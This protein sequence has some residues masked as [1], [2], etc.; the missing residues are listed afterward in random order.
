MSRQAVRIVRS[1]SAALK[2]LERA[3]SDRNS[4][5]KVGV[6]GD[7][8]ARPEKG[9]TNAEV[10]VKHEYGLD[11]L[12]IRSF[13]RMPLT[14]KFE[15]KLKESPNFRPEK[16][17]KVVEEKSLEEYI[18]GMGLVGEDVVRDAFDTGG[19]G[20]WTPSNMARKNNHQTLVETQNLRNSITSEVVLDK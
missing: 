20:E 15:K 1:N 2:G 9:K 18:R 13:L 8:N 6:L 10:G 12:P 5:A 11:G 16:F 14:T 17:N 7:R 19:F 4:H 3:F